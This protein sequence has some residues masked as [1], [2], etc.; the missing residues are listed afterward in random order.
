MPNNPLRKLINEINQFIFDAIDVPVFIVDENLRIWCANEEAKS[1]QDGTE[2]V[3]KR[4]C[5]EVFSCIHQNESKEICGSTEFCK[6]CTMREIVQTT[7]N[8][9]KS[10]LKNAKMRIIKKNE[11]SDMW[12]K[13]S[14]KPLEYEGK[15][16]A[17]LTFQENTELME[18]RSIIPICMYCRKVRDDEQYWQLLE[19]YLERHQEIKF[20]HG[21]CPDCT[22]KHFPEYQKKITP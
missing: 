18:L 4:L 6:E 20:S 21:I 14:A 13:I 9:T 3:I 11:A 8:S 22:G 17:V 5:G 2:V 10:E 19:H 15:I 16:Y 1:F 7:C 12:L